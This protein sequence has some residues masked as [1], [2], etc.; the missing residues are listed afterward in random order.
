MGA[1]G[2]VS[3]VGDLYRWQLAFQQGKVLSKESLQAYSSVQFR[4]DS[5][6]G[7]GYGWIVSDEP[8]HRSRASAGGNPELGHNNV[9]RWFMDEDILLIASTSNDEIKAE[10]VVPNLARIVYDRPYQL[11]PKTVSVSSSIL[12]MYI[13]R[14]QIAEG[15]TCCDTK[16]EQTPIYGRRTASFRYALQKWTR[17]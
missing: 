17:D 6:G 13:G 2:M 4:L 1:G 11:P 7:E 12:D 16:R 9:I 10:D 8:G 3:S 15:N 5:R 14:Y